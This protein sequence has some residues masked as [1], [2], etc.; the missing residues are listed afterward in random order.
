MA[1][2]EH[3]T[4]VTACAGT[5]P[6]RAVVSAGS[7]V[8][9][10]PASGTLTDST[11]GAADPN[12]FRSTATCCFWILCLF[13]VWFLTT[14]TTGFYTV[15]IYVA[16]MCNQVLELLNLIFRTPRERSSG[17]LNGQ[18]KAQTIWSSFQILVTFDLHLSCR[19][20]RSGFYKIPVI[21]HS[22]HNLSWMD[23]QY[24]F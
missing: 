6:Y 19:I 1:R 7:W 20:K 12:P 4:G 14:C 13:A 8:R 22:F 24:Y 21:V 9:M 15:C 3:G 11:E 5:R 17:L 18:N 16:L 10:W 23:K 2:S